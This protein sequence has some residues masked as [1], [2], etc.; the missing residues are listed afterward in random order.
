[1]D[2]LL[3]NLLLNWRI[4]NRGGTD[5]GRFELHLVVVRYR[6][7]RM[8]LTSRQIFTNSTRPGKTARRTPSGCVPFTSKLCCTGSAY[9]RQS[10]QA[11]YADHRW[12]G[13]RRCGDCAGPAA[14]TDPLTSYRR[15]AACRRAGGSFKR[16]SPDFGFKTPGRICSR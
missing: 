6:W 12:T 11:G 8:V 4:V 9:R 5:T 10:F 16:Q 7:A 14:K 15:F 13:F 1:M 3:L 2:G